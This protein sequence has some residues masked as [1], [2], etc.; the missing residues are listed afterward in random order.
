MCA[1]GFSGHEGMFFPRF[2]AEAFVAFLKET[3]AGNRTA[4]DE[5]SGLA[6]F[7]GGECVEEIYLQTFILRRFRSAYAASRPP[8]FAS[9]TCVHWPPRMGRVDSFDVLAWRLGRNHSALYTPFSM[10]R[11]TET[12]GGD[13][14]DVL[15][16]L[17]AG[18]AAAVPDLSDELRVAPDRVLQNTTLECVRR[19]H[20]HLSEADGI[21]SHPNPDEH[22]K[23]SLLKDDPYPD[24]ASLGRLTRAWLE[25]AWAVR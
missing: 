12:R 15:E 11:W 8:H 9:T 7:P 14:D 5:T 23:K 10:K 4:W 16:C 19:H 24:M 1:A 2:V 13:D 20:V 17:G 3:S 21:G 22:R 25:D 6:G 18:D